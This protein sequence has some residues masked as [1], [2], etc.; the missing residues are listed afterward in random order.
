MSGMPRLHLGSYRSLH[1]L[2]KS[3]MAHVPAH[4]L[5]THGVV[6]GMT[7]SGKTGL[8]TVLV[9]EAMRASVP[10]L[11]IDV[12][13]DLPNL[14]LAFP[15]FDPAHVAPWVESADEDPTIAAKQAEERR[16]GLESYGIGAAELAAFANETHV[17]V[18]TPGADAGEL[19]HVLSSLERRSPR[20]DHD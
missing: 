1:D 8:V 15:S 4:H 13:G 16:V 19:L 12:K 9:E 14:L 7:G 20:W 10:V 11:V 17:R 18:I 2:E 6:V 5:V 3:G